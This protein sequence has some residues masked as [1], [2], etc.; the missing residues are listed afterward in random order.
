VD[1]SARVPPGCPKEVIVLRES[2]GVV[3]RRDPLEGSPGGS[4]EW[5]RWRGTLEGVP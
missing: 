5:V 1:G 2:R 4:L 3:H